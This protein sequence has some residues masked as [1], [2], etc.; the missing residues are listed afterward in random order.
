M[1]EILNRLARIKKK[2][3]T[4][5]IHGNKLNASDDPMP[6]ELIRPMAAKTPKSK[7]AVA[8]VGPKVIN[9]PPPKIPPMIAATAD[10][11]RP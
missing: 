10:P 5:K 8:F 2:D 4:I 11:I 6:L 9:L 3:E 7:T 1:K